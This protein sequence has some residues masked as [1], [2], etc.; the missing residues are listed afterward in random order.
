MHNEIGEHKIPNSHYSLEPG[1]NSPVPVCMPSYKP[2]ARANQRSELNSHRKWLPDVAPMSC[3]CI[4][5]S[6]PRPARDLL[7]KTF[8]SKFKPIPSEPLERSLLRSSFAIDLTFIQYCVWA[9]LIN[10]IIFAWS[11]R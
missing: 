5:C 4:D 7:K 11:G 1:A 10:A 6:G 3:R 2:A 8:R 9:A